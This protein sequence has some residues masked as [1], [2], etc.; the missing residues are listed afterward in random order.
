MRLHCC[1]IS[2][3]LSVCVSGEKSE[4]GRR[5]RA[6]GGTGKKQGRSRCLR[7]SFI[8]KKR[9]PVRPDQG[10]KTTF[11]K[12]IQRLEK[13]RKE[14]GFAEIYPT[15]CAPFYWCPF[16]VLIDGMR[17]KTG[18]LSLPR[19]SVTRIGQF[20]ARFQSKLPSQAILAQ[21]TTCKAPCTGSFVLQSAKIWSHS[22]STWCAS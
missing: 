11:M 19:N 1:D 2:L 20:E 13:V 8:N 22:P 7:G 21:S 9:P 15:F 3:Y 16:A 10:Q 14:A 17:Q 6:G 12:A 18:S 5:G 4:R